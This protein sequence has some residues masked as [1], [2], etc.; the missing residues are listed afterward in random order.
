LIRAFIAITPPEA[1][2]SAMHDV[3]EAFRPQARS[4]RWIPPENV[5]LTLKFLGD[6]PAAALPS[7]A[8]AMEQAVAEQ[9]LFALRMQNLGCFPS[10]SRPRVLWMGLEDTQGALAGIYGR[11]EAAL[12]ALGY[13]SETRPFRPHLTLA[14][15]RQRGDTI[16]R[17][18]LG[19]LL[20]AFRGERFGE[21][22]VGHLHLYRSDLRKEGAIYTILHTVPLRQ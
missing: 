17:V 3:R 5:H 8:Q 16:D 6:V 22:V 11:L 12:A 14:R 18:Q 9:P 21:F 7:L 10:L 4:W 1:L 2:H 20:N 13:A 15:A 19:S